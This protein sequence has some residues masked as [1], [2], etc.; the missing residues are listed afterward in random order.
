MVYLATIITQNYLIILDI[1][2]NLSESPQK[3]SLNIAYV[4]YDI[5]THK[6]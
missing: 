4:S 1:I 2:N 3:V 6:N 5:V